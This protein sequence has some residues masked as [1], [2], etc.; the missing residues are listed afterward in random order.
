LAQIAFGGGSE[1]AAA[2]LTATASLDPEELKQLVEQAWLKDGVATG[3]P[4]GTMV[5]VKVPDFSVANSA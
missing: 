1:Q 4:A 3:D 5:V 2:R